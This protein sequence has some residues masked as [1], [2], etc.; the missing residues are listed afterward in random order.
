[1]SKPPFRD[2]NIIKGLFRD[3]NIIKPTPPPPPPGLFLLMAPSFL[4][5]LQRSVLSPTMIIRNQA[6]NNFMVMHAIIMVMMRIM[7]IAEMVPNIRE[8]TG[9]RL[10]SINY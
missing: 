6:R 1:M 3:K 5:L 4:S 2:K 10:F 7:N 8:L 9:N